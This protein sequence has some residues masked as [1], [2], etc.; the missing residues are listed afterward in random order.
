MLNRVKEKNF[1]IIFTTVYDQLC[2]KKVIRY[3]AFDYLLKPVDIDEL[4]RAIETIEESKLPKTLNRL[5][6][7]NRICGNLKIHIQ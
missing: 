2:Y 6:C 4:K 7:C 5:N 3:A 1:H